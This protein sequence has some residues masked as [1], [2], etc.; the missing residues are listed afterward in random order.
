MKLC[1]KLFS[2]MIF[3]VEFVHLTFPRT[4]ISNFVET[5]FRRILEL[6]WKT[7]DMKFRECRSDTRKLPCPSWR[8]IEKGDDGSSIGLTVRIER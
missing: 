6:S 2:R 4:D 7:D 5:F 8:E 1:S 3:I